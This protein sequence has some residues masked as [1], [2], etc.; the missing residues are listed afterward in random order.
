MG[1]PYRTLHRDD[2]TQA[3]DLSGRQASM[4]YT[5][6]FPSIDD[7][8]VSF[9]SPLVSLTHRLRREESNMI[10]LLISRGAA[11]PL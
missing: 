1:S 5:A 3:Y 10:S 6:D 7:D 9:I 8:F 2:A 4:P 11:D